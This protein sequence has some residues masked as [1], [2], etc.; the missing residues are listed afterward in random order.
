M[1]RRVLVKQ[2]RTVYFHAFIKKCRA[3]HAAASADRLQYILAEVFIK[4]SL[5]YEEISN[6]FLVS[7]R[8]VQLDVSHLCN[9][10]S[11]RATQR[12]THSRRAAACI[13]DLIDTALQHLQPREGIRQHMKN[14]RV[15][16][17]SGSLVHAQYSLRTI[18]YT[19]S[20]YGR[21]AAGPRTRLAALYSTAAAC[22]DVTFC[23]AGAARRALPLAVLQPHWTARL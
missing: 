21:H 20:F 4:S 9:G 14:E 23:R 3:G 11:T 8:P 12:I 1:S 7:L 13:V 2:L 16:E 15:S 10:R 6:C 17:G 19:T 22:I 18:S 5:S